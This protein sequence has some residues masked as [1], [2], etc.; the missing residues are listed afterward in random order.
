MTGLRTPL[1]SILNFRDV[2]EFV[3]GVTGTNRLKTGLLYRSARPDE[4]SLE[5]R[6]RLTTEYGV[7][8]II[9]LRTKTEHIE[10]AQKRDAK[11]KASAAIPQ[12]NDNVAEPLKIPGITYHEINFNGSAFSRMLLSKLSW[13]E[14]FRLIGLMVFGY[15]LD[16][17]KILAPHMEEMELVGL[18]KSSLDVCT[19][20]VK[21]VFDVFTDETNWPVLV[22]CTQGKDRTGLVVMLVLFLLG[23]EQEIIQQDYMLSQSEL[24]PEKEERIKEIQ[25]I[26][27]SEKFAICPLDVVSSVHLHLQE[28]YGG[29][30]RYLEK[31][32]ISRDTVNFMKQKLLVEAMFT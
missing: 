27:L 16:A 31:I 7:K 32:G 26:G 5:D 28:E 3:N 29:V 18:A 12:T 30:E 19:H 15:R 4:S 20:E 17:I 11:I 24:A 2:S 9:D 21:Q 8:S 14:F 6:Q 25:S 1:K 13:I 23:V 10:Q 22:H